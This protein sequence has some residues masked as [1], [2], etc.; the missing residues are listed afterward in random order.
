MHSSLLVIDKNIK[1]VGQF[2]SKLVHGPQLFWFAMLVVRITA[3][4]PIVVAAS[5]IITTTSGTFRTP[6]S[7]FV[8]YHESG[9]HT[10]PTVCPESHPPY[11]IIVPFYDVGV[12]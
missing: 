2:V 1:F 10:L 4:P 8:V 5:T 7:F 9:P 12:M 6:G 11:R 3:H